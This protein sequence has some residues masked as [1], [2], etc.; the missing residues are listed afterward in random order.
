MN[1]RRHLLMS[2]LTLLRI[3]MLIEQPPLLYRLLFPEAFWRVKYPSEKPVVFLTFDDGPVP[4]VTPR[5]LDLLDELGVKATFFMVGDNVRRHP[6][7]L[8]EV[9]RRGHGVGNHTMHHLQGMRTR[10]VSYLRDVAEADALIGSR[11]FRPPHGIMR[12]G[13]ARAIKNRY[14][15]IMY[16]V[17]SR[18]YNRRLS[19]ER[20][21]DNVRR[22]TRD[23]SIIVFHDSL[24]A[25]DN[26]LAAMPRAV[27][28]L[29]EQGY[30]FRTL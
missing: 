28:W 29:K 12:W 24:K 8:E 20:I 1:R 23:G 18:D 22:Y 5:V 30:E 27:R 13:Q 21:F 14:N 15:I 26:M 19:P 25:R 6:E 10:G 16:D 7:L 11:L 2:V 3:L 17:V 4:E 9:R